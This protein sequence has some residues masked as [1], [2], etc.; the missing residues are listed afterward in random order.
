MGTTSTS[1]AIYLSHNL[2]AYYN[3]SIKRRFSTGYEADWVDITSY[4]LD[5]GAAKISYKLD[6]EDFGWG[7]FQ[8]S[9][10]TFKVN[11]RGGVFFPP[12]YGAVSLFNDAISRHYTKIKYEAGYK[13]ENG[14]NITEQVFQ[15]LLNEKSIS[16]NFNTGEMNIVAVSNQTIFGERVTYA[17]S[18][19]GAKTGTEIIS[20]VMNRADIISNVEFDSTKINVGFNTLFDDSSKYNGRKYDEVLSEIAKKTNSAWYVDM[21]TNKLTFKARTIIGSLKYKFVGGNILSRDVNIVQNGIT[22]YN[23]G[24]DKI[25]NVVKYKKETEES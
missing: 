21:I 17:G 24:F 23:E 11:N 9:N 3:I 8:A 25:I 6:T 20:W 12:N 10:A 22:K 13:D 2:K 5:K 15:G 14:T 1:Q 16:T 18:M 7:E 19:T 4:L